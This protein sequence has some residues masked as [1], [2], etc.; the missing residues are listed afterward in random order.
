MAD[1]LGLAIRNMF[2]VH[3]LLDVLRCPLAIH[4]VPLCSFEVDVW[5]FGVIIYTMIIGRPPFETSDVKAT[6]KRIKD[7]AYGFPEGAP[8]SPA[9]RDLIARILVPNPA[10]RPTLEGIARHAWFS[11]PDAYMPRRLPRTCL[12]EAPMFGPGDLLL[13]AP[14]MADL[15]ARPI[16]SLYVRGSKSSSRSGGS[17]S[18]SGS[19]SAA[20]GAGAGAGAVYVDGP[21]DA[22]AGA[23]A[24]SSSR[25]GSVASAY[26][27]ADKENGGYYVHGTGKPFAVGP[28]AAA[29]GGAAAYEGSA[30][31]RAL[32]PASSAHGNAVVTHPHAGVA[33]AKASM[34]AAGGA[35]GGM[36]SADVRVF[37]D[38]PGGMASPPP[39]PSSSSGAGPGGFGRASSTG[40]SYGGDRGGRESGAS[41]AASYGTNNRAAYASFNGTPM[42]D[43]VA[44]DLGAAALAP[45]H[46]AS[47]APTLP[48][49]HMAPGASGSAPSSGAS[50]SAAA[51]SASSAA[52][53]AA[54]AR[55]RA[56]LGSMG[57]GEVAERAAAGAAAAA[58]SKGGYVVTVQGSSDDRENV[59][60]GSSSSS[61]TRPK[62]GGSGSASASGSPSSAFK[63]VGGRAAAGAVGGSGAAAGAGA[64]SGSG[65]GSGSTARPTLSLGL[66]LGL[67]A[68]TGVGHSLP[69]HAAPLSSTGAPHSVSLALPPATGSATSTGPASAYASGRAAAHAHAS[70]R[71]SGSGARSTPG[72]SASPHAH[73][74]G[75]AG[76]AGPSAA[77]ASAGAS[78]PLDDTLPSMYTYLAH[79][80]QLGHSDVSLHADSAPMAVP[81]LAPAASPATPR[82]R[83]SSTASGSGSAKSRRTRSSTKEAASA[84][85]GAGAGAAPGS[86]MA[87]E[88]D[89]ASTSS[90]SSSAAASAYGPVDWHRTDGW[91]SASAAAAAAASAAGS[92]GVPS[93]TML[94]P[95]PLAVAQRLALRAVRPQPPSMRP[96]LWVT[97]WVDFTSKY[98]VGYMLS[99]AAVGVYFN[100]STKIALSADGRSFE[101]VERHNHGRAYPTTRLTD[102]PSARIV[103]GGDGIFRIR[104]TLDRFPGELAKK[105]TLLRHFQGHLQDQFRK[106]CV[107]TE[108]AVVAARSA[109]RSGAHVPP[110]LPGLLPSVV[111]EGGL[112]AAAPGSDVMQA[113]G[114]GL[115]GGVPVLVGD[116]EARL[117]EDALTSMRV[118]DLRLGAGDR[119]AAAGAGAAGRGMG[120]DGEGDEDKEDAASTGSGGSLER[121]PL[122][123]DALA[124]GG[125]GDGSSSGTSASSSSAAAQQVF[126]PFVKKYVRSRRC[127]M[128]RLSNR[129]VQLFFYDGTQM[130]LSGDGRTATYTDRRANRF[131]FAARELLA[132]RA[133]LTSR[134]PPEMLE[135]TDGAFAWGGQGD[136]SAA[137]HPSHAN[138]WL[139]IVLDAQRRLK[140][141]KDSL[142]QWMGVPAGAGAASAAAAPAA[143]SGSAAASASAGGVAGS[144]SASH[145]TGSRASGM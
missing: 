70:D 112:P 90:T 92:Y 99:N 16:G 100:D 105:V 17:G 19:G 83:A 114:H 11:A 9:A 81:V 54:G 93:V 139:R 126:L 4:V 122:V 76:V 28:S 57:A 102:C 36:G 52:A 71:S 30:G 88:D 40:S 55:R 39:L 96:T 79:C 91:A 14:F 84:S 82:G 65:S 131:V 138:A 24:G 66:G 12:K 63:H 62:S 46:R 37:A 69:A 136:C 74:H 77:G 132:T 116:E 60:A 13:G 33:G 73:A 109:S 47:S 1:R 8:I 72:P 23:G 103:Q 115:N 26:G 27:G 119:A 67:G 108:A 117:H 45:L 106:R 124:C 50:A 61:S 94:H 98:G 86:A 22:A 6:Y 53:A 107:A 58:G 31:S 48:S 2:Y 34:L 89:A 113:S 59:V 111:M 32:G 134:V 141:A 128:F 120:V 44:T 42:P 20:G 95:P 144:A 5:A 145:R 125:T 35:G 142:G 29:A 135:S 75:S 18:G 130:L 21:E 49:V 7:N 51:A 133:S 78:A 43:H 25:R 140:Y 143:G 97:G 110:A 101:Y 104:A 127:M 68:S 15:F 80:E 56:P 121:V 41:S 64:G 87:V 137:A 3:L 129:S 123:G 118:L 85:T 10:E 38:G